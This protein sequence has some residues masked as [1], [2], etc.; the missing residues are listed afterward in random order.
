MRERFVE[1]SLSIIVCLILLLV[2]GLISGCFIPQK[3]FTDQHQTLSLKQNELSA[4]GI[5][6][7]TPSTAT[8]GRQP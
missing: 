5:A 6:F 2:N 1:K 3:Q 4:N 7:I 8:H